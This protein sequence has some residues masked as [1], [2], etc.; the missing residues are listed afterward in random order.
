MKELFTVVAIFLLSFAS[1]AQMAL[2]HSYS[3][4]IYSPT[5]VV[6]LLISGKKYVSYSTQANQMTLYNLNHT[7]W[8]TITF[9][10]VAGLAPYGFLNAHNSELLGWGYVSEN[11]FKIDN[12]V[13]I[14]LAYMDTSTT[15][16]GSFAT[17]LL[18]FDE[19]GSIIN[20]IDSISNFVV[21][22]IGVDSFVGLAY[23]WQS[24]GGISINRTSIYSLP[25]KLPCNICGS[26]PGL[27]VPPGGNSNGGS[28]LISNPVPNPSSGSVK[29]EYSV[30]PGTTGTIRVFNTMGK[31]L[32]NYKVDHNFDYITLDNTELPSGIYYYN[33]TTSD[34]QTSAKKMIVVR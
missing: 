33:L 34:M 17:H 13:D 3:N 1:K 2:Q 28:S 24:S 25:G 8:K 9:P 27:G 6:D 29:I 26:A 7:L 10:S 21:S 11:L 4:F 18:V 22:N 12:K 15:A 23:L 31:E 19:T 14:A 30:P 16:L 5:L 20:R 32:K